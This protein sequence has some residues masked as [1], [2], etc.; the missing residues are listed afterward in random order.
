MIILAS[1]SLTRQRLLRAAGVAFEAQ[2]P[3]TDEQA[4]KTTHPDLTAAGLAQALA[5]AKATSLSSRFPDTTIIGCDQ[6]LSCD[7]RIFDKPGSA[8]EALQHLDFLQGK[9]HT[10]YTALCCISGSNIAHE[11]ISEPNLSMRSLSRPYLE[12]YLQKAG[13]DILGCVGCYQIEGLGAQL[14]EAIDGDM[15]SI[16]GLPLLQLLAYL[17]ETGNLAA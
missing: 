16:Q 6:V 1:T 5:R 17:R 10:L 7:N 9:T 11:V 3:P 8:E 14:F 13:P 15:F 2:R 4:F 12:A